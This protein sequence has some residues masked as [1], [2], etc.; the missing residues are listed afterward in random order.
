MRTIIY[1]IALMLGFVKAERV[2][3]TPNFLKVFNE[4]IFKDDNDLGYC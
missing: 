4:D 2:A 1:K 3:R